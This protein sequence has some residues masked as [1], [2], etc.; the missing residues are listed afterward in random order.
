MLVAGKHQSFYE[1]IDILLLLDDPIVVMKRSL[2]DVPGWG[3]L[4][5][6]Y[7][8]IPIDREGGAATL[9]AIIGA[10]REAAAKVA[11]QALAER[12]TIRA[13][14]LEQGWVDR[15]ALTE[16]QLDEALDVLAMTRPPT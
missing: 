9:R 11:K 15:G 3:R 14:V 10:A 12:T 2:V 5:Q 13:V 1:A 16:E 7:G 8:V 4:A 6:A